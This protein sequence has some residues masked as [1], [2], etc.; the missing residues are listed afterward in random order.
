MAKSTLWMRGSVSFVALRE[1][2]FYIA[3]HPDGVRAREMDTWAREKARLRTQEGKVVSKTTVYHYR[4]TLLHL[5]IVRRQSGRYIVNREK[6]HVNRLLRVLNPGIP[7][8]SLEERKLFAELIIANAEC[9]HYFF[10]IF[11]PD[12]RTEYDLETWLQK[13]QPAVWERLTTSEGRFERIYNLNHP[14]KELWLR[15]EDERQA[16]L[17]GVRYWARNE[18]GFLDELFLEDIGGLMF[19]VH[20]TGPIPDPRILLA[21]RDKINPEEEWNMFSVRTLAATWGPEYRISLER[22]YKTLLW[23]YRNFMR[24][25]ILIPTTASFATITATSPS[26]EQYHLR[27]YMQDLE[28][29]YISHIRVHRKLKEVIQCPEVLNVWGYVSIRLNQQQA[30]HH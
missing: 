7:S 20:L 11:M 21:L 10:D 28:G 30:G 5:G 6:S 24:Y 4:N 13:G 29:R 25:V 26:T 8:L 23:V 3:Q 18:L 9:R 27:G 16:I 12:T 17:Y 2:L 15:T 22:L 1:L 19:P 14:E